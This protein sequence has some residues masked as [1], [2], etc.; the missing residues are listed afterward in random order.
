MFLEFGDVTGF[1]M[2]QN[3][4]IFAFCEQH[5][6][7]SIPGVDDLTPGVFTLHVQYSQGISPSIIND[8]ITRHVKSYSVPTQ[9]PSRIFRMPLAFDDGVCRAAIKRY[10]NTIRHQAP[11]LPNKT[12]FIKF[13]AELNGLETVA[14]LLYEASFLV[15][16]LG[17]VFMGSPCANPID[18]RHRLFGSKY[19]LSRSFTPR[20]AVG[21]GGQYMCIYA[22]DS[23]G[24][25]QLV[26]RTKEIWDHGCASICSGR[27]GLIDLGAGSPELVRIEESVL[28]LTEYE[29]WL[30]K[31]KLDIESRKAH[32]ARA[33]SSSPFIEELAR[34]YLQ[35][36][37]DSGKD[38][39]QLGADTVPGEWIQAMMPG[40]CY[41]INVEEGDIVNK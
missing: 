39:P 34:P 7:F 19:N 4:E 5:S 17:D 20:G 29:S 22:T 38:N 8:H 13:L 1:D 18:P 3:F 37:S 28:D 27:D 9:V 15:L 6:K 24:G 10:E 35:P 40:R 26:G 32:Q 30:A 41:K 21:I 14:D 16:G 31:N 11:W 33:I 23:P 36:N 25:Y 12:E 2:R